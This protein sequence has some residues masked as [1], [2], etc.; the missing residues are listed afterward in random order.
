MN[1][2]KCLQANTLS[3]KHSEPFQMR[4]RDSQELRQ[5]Q[6]RVQDERDA[7]KTLIANIDEQKRKKLDASF[8]KVK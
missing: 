5:S 2:Y 8:S 3:R 4:L 7:V 6:Q 1:K